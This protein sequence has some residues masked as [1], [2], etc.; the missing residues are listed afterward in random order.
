LSPRAVRR[1]KLLSESSQTSNSARRM[2]RKNISSG[3]SRMNT[4]STPSISTVP[5]ISGRTRS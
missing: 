2:A 1:Q 3:D 5:S 4:G